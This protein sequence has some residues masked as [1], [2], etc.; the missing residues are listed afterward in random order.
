M[1]NPIKM[2]DLGV[3]LFSETSIF[4]FWDP[5]LNLYFL[6]VSGRRAHIRKICS[7]KK[8]AVCHAPSWRIIFPGLG[9]GGS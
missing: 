7:S 6:M 3:P 9:L 8:V 5:K 2:D 1:E 4:R